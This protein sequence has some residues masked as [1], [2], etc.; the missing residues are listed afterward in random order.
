M[1][2]RENR[3][4]RQV[5]Y[6]DI[7]DKVFFNIILELGGQKGFFSS[8]PHLRVGD[9]QGEHSGDMGHQSLQQSQGHSKEQSPG[10]DLNRFIN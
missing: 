3:I 8:L 5:G 10:A 1:Y 6:L 4:V 7:V 9:Q 2:I